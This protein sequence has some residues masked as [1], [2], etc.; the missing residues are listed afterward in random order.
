MKL[1]VFDERVLPREVLSA[2]AARKLSSLLRSVYELDVLLQRGRMCECLFAVRAHLFAHAAVNAFVHYEVALLFE[3]P[4]TP[5]KRTPIAL[6]VRVRVLTIR[7][8]VYK[9]FATA[10]MAAHQQQPRKVNGGI[11]S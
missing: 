4:R 3:A 8:A 11:C 10:A 1:K 2:A 7:L 6:C 9:P 5:I